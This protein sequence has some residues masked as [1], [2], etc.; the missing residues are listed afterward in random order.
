MILPVRE[1]L[2]KQRRTR[3]YHSFRL[4]LELMKKKTSKHMQNKVLIII[5]FL[6]THPVHDVKEGYLFL[7]I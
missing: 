4:T 7:N 3:L 5:I 6:L 1:P 2:E